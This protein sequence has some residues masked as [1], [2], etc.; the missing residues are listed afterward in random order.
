M[1][2]IELYQKVRVELFLWVPELI[3]LLDFCWEEKTN[4]SS[5]L[6]VYQALLPIRM[7][8]DPFQNLYAGGNRGFFLPPCVNMSVRCWRTLGHQASLHL[9]CCVGYILGI[10]LG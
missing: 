6:I 7:V 10:I 4:A 8:D 9:N 1:E 5:I 2:L 3:V